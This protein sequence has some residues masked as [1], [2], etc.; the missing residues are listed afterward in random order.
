MQGTPPAAVDRATAPTAPADLLMALRELI[1]AGERYR[2]VVSRR[3]NLTVTE[4]QAVSYLLARGP[5]G[6]TDLARAL[7]LTTSSTT[8]L[9]DRLERRGL[10]NRRPHRTDRRRT[11]VSLTEAGEG[12]MGGARDWLENA[13]AEVRG[14]PPEVIVLIL[15]SITDS[16][17]ATIERLAA[18]P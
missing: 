14:A 10:A 4:S 5:M 1:L 15:R 13:L 12:E 6:Q 17:S 11:V 16:L 8:A 7:G 2:A 9:V 3:L 18:E